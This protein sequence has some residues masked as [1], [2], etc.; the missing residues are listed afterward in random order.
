M[1]LSNLYRAGNDRLVLKEYLNKLRRATR[2]SGVLTEGHKITIEID[3]SGSITTDA[4]ENFIKKAEELGNFDDPVWVEQ[5][6]N[7]MKQVGVQGLNKIDGDNSPVTRS[8]MK[9]LI[10]LLVNL[11]HK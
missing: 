4:K 5:L 7:G 8:E 2:L 6:V 11:L 1:R 10:G 9:K 3:D